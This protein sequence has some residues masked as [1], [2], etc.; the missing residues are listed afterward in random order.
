[1][2]IAWPEI[3]SF[4]NIRKYTKA[5]PEILNG[6]PKVSY[7]PKVKLHGTNAAVRVLQDGTVLAQSR[8]QIITPE[9]DN[10]GFAK[11]VKANEKAW[12]KACWLETLYG[13]GH[14]VPFMF[15]GEWVGPGVQKGV[16]VSEIPKKS[17]AVFAMRTFSQKAEEVDD[18]LLNRHLDL[19]V[20]DIPDTYVLD[21]YPQ[22]I[23]IDWS[24]SAEDLQTQV[25]QINQWV[26]DVEKND[27]WVEEVFN[28]K[29]TGEGLV[30]YPTSKEHQG[31]NNFSNLCFKAKGEKHK[32]IKTAAPAQVDA[33]VAANIDQ[34]VD[35]VLTDARLDQGAT[36]VGGLDPKLTG[37][38]VQWV[39]GD[40]QKETQDELEASKLSWQDVSK[41]ITTK[42]RTW[43]LNKSK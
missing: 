43:Y 42:A 3:E 5:H 13:D 8:T 17:F 18:N 9:N 21:W 6:N 15:Y 35:M 19:Y 26:E 16:T 28:V 20:K 39:C 22:S 37:K 40:V 33:E 27:P 24:S 4:H 29:G 32:N 31:F 7:K 10:A 41:A 30:F 1:M 34:F 12:Q 23:E 14:Y 11:W 2:F 25:N 38:F 36:A